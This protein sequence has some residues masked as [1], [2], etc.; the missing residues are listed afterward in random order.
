MSRF[1][2]HASGPFRM[3]DFKSG[4]PIVSGKILFKASRFLL[5]HGYGIEA[6][7]CEKR[8]FRWGKYI[9]GEI[10]TDNEVDGEVLKTIKKDLG[11]NM[12]LKKSYV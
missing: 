8:N 10:V 1:P 6:F 9:V 5:T 7:E 3:S 4:Y 2:Y 12:R 11:V